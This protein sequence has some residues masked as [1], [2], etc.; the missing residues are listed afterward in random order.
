MHR[1]VAA[2]LVAVLVLALASCGGAESL[3]RAELVRRIEAA[4]NT[5]QAQMRARGGGEQGSFLAA[6]AASQR[7]VVKTVSKLHP[8]DASKADF[9]TFKQGLEQRLAVFTRA[10]SSVRSVGVA[11]AVRSVQAEGEVITKRL[12]TA[13][14]RL[15]ATGCF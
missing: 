13:A 4:C 15:G 3:T 14:T 6:I 2:A 5:A 8:P 11:S 12:R 7:V 9:E 1:T 10:E